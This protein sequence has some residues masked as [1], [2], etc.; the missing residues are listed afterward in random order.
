M[1]EA[2]K[3]PALDA[4]QVAAWRVNSEGVRVSVKI[5]YALRAMAELAA[6]GADHPS[7]AEE[8]AAR[9]QIPA[10]FLLGILGELKKARLVKSIRG[11][12]GGFQLARPA[13]EISLADVIRAIEGPLANVHEESLRALEYPGAAAALP[14]VWMAVRTSLR[15]VLEEISLDELARGRL[16]P[17]VRQM[18]RRY[19][20]EE[21]R[22]HR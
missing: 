12:D 22:R 16:P 18:T 3:V 7:R 1:P 10:K 21:R 19:L 4:G 20:A 14:D 9:Q 13:K 6:E 8:L 2:E 17:H 5:D 11:R 15:E